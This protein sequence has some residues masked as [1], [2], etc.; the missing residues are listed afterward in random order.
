MRG[1]HSVSALARNYPMSFAA[2]QKHVSVLEGA[3]LIRK[4]QRGR[5]RLVCT[6]IDTIRT[7]NHLLEQLEALWRSRIERIEGILDDQG[8]TE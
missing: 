8:D 3:G 4:E 1:E 6:N 5:E 2:V 7:A